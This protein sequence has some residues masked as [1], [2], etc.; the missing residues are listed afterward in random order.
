MVHGPPVVLR[1]TNRR[2]VA[3]ARP[4]QSAAAATVEIPM[5]DDRVLGKVPDVKISGGSENTGGRPAE[6]RRYRS[7]SA[8]DVLIKSANG[9]NV[10]QA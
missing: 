8:R 2:G 9:T 5:V 4:V 7:K 6:V 1:H 10:M 3:L